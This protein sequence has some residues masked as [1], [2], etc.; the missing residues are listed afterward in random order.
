[1]TNPTSVATLHTN[2]GDIKVNLFG[3]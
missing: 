1:M 3:L 2:H